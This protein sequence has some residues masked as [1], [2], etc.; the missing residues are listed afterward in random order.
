MG[1]IASSP[2]HTP[3]LVPVTLLGHIAEATSAEPLRLG[4]LTIDLAAHE[5]WGG[6][7]RIELAHREFAL[8]VF[9]LE[10]RG[11]VCN[12][13]AIVSAVW[14]D[15]RLASHRT[16]DIHVYRLRTKLAP[17]GALIETVRHVGYIVRSP[18]PSA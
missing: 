4:P 9:L 6:G 2:L 13:T 18:T 12:R 5:V 7:R 17:H 14:A 11:R 16:V 10:R 15:R 1:P 3:A 8:L